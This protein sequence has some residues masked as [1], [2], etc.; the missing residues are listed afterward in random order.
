MVI[1]I[2]QAVMDTSS[3][4][5]LEV[6]D[7]LELTSENIEIIVPSAVVEELREMSK[8]SDR[9]GEVAEDILALI[10]KEK[11]S[12]V[13]VDS[14]KVRKITSSQVEKG[15][16]SCFVH[17]YEKGVRNLIMDDIEAASQLEGRTIKEGIRQKISVAVI[18]E[19]MK[20]ELITKEEA[21]SAVEKLKK[22][23]DWR[24]GVLE[25]LADKY[26]SNE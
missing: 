10:S 19:L 1:Q 26:L 8:I 22:T 7:I 21:E 9:E 5:S 2:S 25:A 3:L 12:V 24:G 15:E 4:I 6:I 23:R 14:E 13:E 17:C 11:I 20:K 16:A 18:I